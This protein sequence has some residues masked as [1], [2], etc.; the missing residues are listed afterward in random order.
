MMR[1]IKRFV[2]GWRELGSQRG[3]TLAEVL[4]ALIISGLLLLGSGEIVR[5]MVVTS[6]TDRDRANALCEVQ[7]VGFWV[8]EDVMQARP[9]GV[10]IG[11]TEGCP[12]DF[13]NILLNIEWTQWNGDENRV[14]YSF[15]PTDDEYSPEGIQLS[16]LTR[17]HLYTPKGDSTIDEGTTVVGEFLD[18]AGTRCEKVMLG[19]ETVVKLDVAAN[20][21]GQVA[22]RTYEIYPRSR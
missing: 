17:Q 15:Y 19:N 10:C 16:K 9:D 12:S 3:F 5:H 8:S 4:I 11:G 18:P 22:S 21:D 2:W 13:P 1:K 7:Y 6:S 14:I 20:V